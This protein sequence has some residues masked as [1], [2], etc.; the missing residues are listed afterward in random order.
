MGKLIILLLA[1]IGAT[2]AR[3]QVNLNCG[4]NERFEVS[5]IKGRLS[6][7]FRDSTVVRTK[8]DDT[9]DTATVI[10]RFDAF[11]LLGD[12]WNKCPMHK[13]FFRI[14]TPGGDTGYINS[15]AVPLIVSEYKMPD[16]KV[17]TII[18]ANISL[19]GHKWTTRLLT[20]HNSNDY[21]NTLEGYPICGDCCS[22][23]KDAWLAVF[24]MNGNKILLE[25]G[26]EFSSCCKS[27]HHSLLVWGEGGFREFLY[28][29]SYSCKGSQ[30]INILSCGEEPNILELSETIRGEY[31]EGQE[32]YKKERILIP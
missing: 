15:K 25:L 23:K 24:R 21:E 32:S 7:C 27:S 10:N 29:E 19:D 30:N 17:E 14:A 3:A 11:R 26:R 1:L 4:E 18:L 31:I 12:E 16:E 8:P 13:L 9:A 5:Q 22:T 6:Y 2:N 20:R 28:F